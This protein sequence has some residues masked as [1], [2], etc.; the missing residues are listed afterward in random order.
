MR[1]K[2]ADGSSVK[3]KTVFI[4]RAAC[5]RKKREEKR[6]KANRGKI[7]KKKNRKKKKRTVSKSEGKKEFS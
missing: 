6:I 1:E 7:T 2:K 4:S 5:I 3:G